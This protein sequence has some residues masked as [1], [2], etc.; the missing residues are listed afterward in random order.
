MFVC[1]IVWL[2]FLKHDS[3]TKQ[4]QMTYKLVGRQLERLATLVFTV[5][6]TASHCKTVTLHWVGGSYNIRLLVTWQNSFRGSS[7]SAHATNVKYR[8]LYTHQQLHKLRTLHS[9]NLGCKMTSVTGETAT[10]YK[11]QILAMRTNM[12]SP[13]GMV[14]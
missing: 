8:L 3:V 9:Y 2:W 6:G 1:V 7:I 10:V 4:Q 13:Y 11:F 12:V 5:Q 14:Y